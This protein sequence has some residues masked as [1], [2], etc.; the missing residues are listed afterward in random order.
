MAHIARSEAEE[1]YG[2]IDVVRGDLADQ[3]NLFGFGDEFDGDRELVNRLDRAHE[4]LMA[5]YPN[6]G[7][8][9]G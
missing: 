1:L 8:N 9:H 7:A 2:I 6:L 3:M 4:I 5:V